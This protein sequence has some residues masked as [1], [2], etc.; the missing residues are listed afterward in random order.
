MTTYWP[1]RNKQL[2]MYHKVVLG[3]LCKSMHFFF[4]YQLCFNKVFAPLRRTARCCCPELPLVPPPPYWPSLVPLVIPIQ[5]FIESIIYIQIY[6]RKQFKSL[7]RKTC[8]WGCSGHSIC[9][10]CLK[11][12]YGLCIWLTAFAAIILFIM[13]L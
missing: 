6:N 11:S 3:T 9:T 1:P 2:S 4:F 13:R 10:E 12:Y 8:N 7:K 5:T